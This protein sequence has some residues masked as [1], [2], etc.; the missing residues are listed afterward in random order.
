M[1][2]LGLDPKLVQKF[3]VKKGDDNKKNY[4]QL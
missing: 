4:M 3:D 1:E 2:D